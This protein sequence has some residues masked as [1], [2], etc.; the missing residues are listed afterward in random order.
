MFLCYNF[1]ENC[2]SDTTKVHVVSRSSNIVL[3]QLEV[4][5]D[6]VL[7]HNAGGRLYWARDT[8]ANEMTFDM[9]HAQGCKIDHS[10]C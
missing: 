5:M 2:E 4:R 10:T 7:G 6:G 3:I 9:N 1:K 8:R